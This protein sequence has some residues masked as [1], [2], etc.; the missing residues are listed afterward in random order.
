MTGRI[1]RLTV[2][3]FSRSWRY[4]ACLRSHGDHGV[5]RRHDYKESA[6]KWTP[7]RIVPTQPIFVVCKG[8]TS[9]KSFGSAT[10]PVVE[11]QS[12]YSFDS[13]S[14]YW[15]QS[16]L[17]PTRFYSYIV[18][19]ST[20]FGLWNPPSHTCPQRKTNLII[21]ADTDVDVDV[22]APMEDA[23]PMD[24]VDEPVS[25]FCEY[26]CVY[27]RERVLACLGEWDEECK[28]EICGSISF[29]PMAYFVCVCIHGER[30]GAFRKICRSVAFLAFAF[31]VGRLTHPLL[32]FVALVGCC[33]SCFLQILV[34][35]SC[36]VYPTTTVW[37][38]VNHLPKD[39]E[40]L[41]G[42]KSR[43]GMR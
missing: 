2:S 37:Y 29:H 1:A 15:Q 8:K 4:W 24:D 34:V 12:L 31:V 21:M 27:V 25:P 3:R 35:R 30:G 7:N 16:T 33:F 32:L 26:M 14:W 5:P 19:K 10:L 28:E 42:L 13:Q 38:R 9:Y 36:T 20:F 6:E 40:F 41:P 22:D 43:N 11:A 39:P 23:A 18:N 17:N